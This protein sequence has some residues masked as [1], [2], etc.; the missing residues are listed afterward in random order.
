MRLNWIDCIIMTPI[1]LWRLIIALSRL[2]NPTEF[3]HNLLTCKNFNLLLTLG[4]KI[5]IKFVF[6]NQGKLVTMLALIIV[7]VIN[8]QNIKIH[9][10]PHKN[11]VNNRWWLINK[12]SPYLS[13]N[14]LRLAW[15]ENV[16]LKNRLVKFR[17]ITTMELKEATMLMKV[18][19]KTKVSNWDLVVKNKLIQPLGIIEVLASIQAKEKLRCPIN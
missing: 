6:Q 16:L 5:W 1:S 2:V 10:S 3:I 8:R 12:P 19:M 9:I 13:S 15:I 11:T 7:F 14:Q 4:K 18:K 17:K